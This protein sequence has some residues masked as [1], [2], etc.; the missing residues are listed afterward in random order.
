M[1]SR[2]LAAL[3]LLAS[4][5][6]AAALVGGARTGMAGTNNVVMIVSTR[7]AICTGTALARD[8]VL[9]AAHCVRHGATYR[10]AG[11]GAGYIIAPRV[12]A[13]HPRFDAR[14]F[15][16]ARAT[17]DLALMK[18]ESPLPAAI[19]TAPLSALDPPPAPGQPVTIAGIGVTTA[20][21]E[22]GI[23]IARSARLVVTGR[24]GSLQIRLTDPA[25]R[26]G[27]AGLGACT[28]DSG[29]PALREDGGRFA[30]I[31]VVSW[32]T[33]PHN[34]S[35][36]GGLTGITPIAR[37]RDWIVATA[38]ALGNPLDR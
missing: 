16:K 27:S 19:A 35:G 12:I 21:S 24:P 20:G 7:G 11:Y 33:G 5:L 18:L 29:A 26:N 2:F 38:R 8:L 34:R 32:S 15:A 28:G 4:T 1:M 3:V 31:G 9:T 36:C 25:T 10:V 22:A 17:A 30:I 14:A 13:R 6:P 37:Y 23:G